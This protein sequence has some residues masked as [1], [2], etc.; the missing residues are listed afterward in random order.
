M[1]IS[2]ETERTATYSLV[3]PGKDGQITTSRI[4]KHTSIR[5]V[6]SEVNTTSLNVT[7]AAGHLRLAQAALER[8][9]WILGDSELAAVP[10]SVMHQNSEGNMPLLKAREN[11]ML[12]RARVLEDKPGAAEAPLRAAAQALAEF[13]RLSPGPRTVK[14]EA[15]RQEIDVY[16]RHVREDHA[17][18]IAQIDL[19][20]DP[21]N[22]WSRQVYGNV[23]P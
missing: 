14:A 7:S 20:L 5:E 4:K 6:T 17:N 15:I 8:E 1:P 16:V 11:L 18:A 22:E 10:N 13:E 19:W 23:L 21:I 12:A 3:K 9:E 2:K